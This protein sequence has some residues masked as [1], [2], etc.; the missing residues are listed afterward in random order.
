MKIADVFNERSKE[1]YRQENA[2]EYAYITAD[3]YS[4]S[5]VIEMEKKVLNILNF[6]LYS[7]TVISFLK[8]YHQILELDKRV[9]ICANYL[10]DLLLLATDSRQFDQSLLASAYIFIS[11]RSL[12]IDIRVSS[13]SLTSIDS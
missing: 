4:A 8:V 7:P 3:E 6:D 5:Q 2:S 12:D 1:Y 10:A 13:F 11:M 9:V